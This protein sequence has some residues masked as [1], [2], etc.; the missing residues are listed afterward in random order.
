MLCSFV[1]WCVVLMVII[2]IIVI[3]NYVLC[4][5]YV[6][7]PVFNLFSPIFLFISRLR[8]PPKMLTSAAYVSRKK[9]KKKAKNRKPAKLKNFRVSKIL[10]LLSPL[11]GGWEMRDENIENGRRERVR[12]LS[13]PFWILDFGFWLL[14]EELC[15]SFTFPFSPLFPFVHPDFIPF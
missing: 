8:H 9:N 1:W 14:V 12:W 4:H 3:N 13:F 15:E 11:A 10:S 7:F 5:V 2:V 6:F